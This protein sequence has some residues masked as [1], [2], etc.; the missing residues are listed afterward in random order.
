MTA[1]GVI[2]INVLHTATSSEY[3]SQLKDELESLYDGE[4]AGG[5]TAAD[6][7][8][9]PKEKIKECLG[10]ANVALHKLRAEKQDLLDRID[11]LKE[12][13]EIKDIGRESM[14]KQTLH[15]D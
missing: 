5:E 15:W 14:Y 10:M 4:Q 13:A 12:N 6:V 11:V 2:G 8:S 3:I 1:W 9:V 7:V